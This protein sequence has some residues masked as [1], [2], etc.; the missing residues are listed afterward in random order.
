M[1]EIETYGWDID[2]CLNDLKKEAA[3]YNEICYCKFNDNRLFSTD[4][5]DDAYLRTVGKTKAEYDK[6]CEQQRLKY[7]QK[8]AE[9]K[10]KI[11]ALEK[12]YKEMARGL[13]IESELEYWDKIVPIRLSDLYHGMELKQTLV[14]CS[15]MRDEKMS[16]DERLRKCYRI[17]MDSGHSGTSANLT[18]AMI[19]RFCPY[20]E[21]LSDA[22]LNF[23]YDKK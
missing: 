5:V 1:K 7:E 21:E 23:T 14:Y 12:E 13:V 16:K 22:V 15:I 20:G 3:K 10:A 19:E 17:F 9:H 6:Y 2:S 4:S 11:P 8:E 18:A